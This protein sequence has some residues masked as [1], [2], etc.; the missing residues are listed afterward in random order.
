MDTCSCRNI[1]EVK[2]VTCPLPLMKS[3][4]LSLD[5]FLSS[6]NLTG[7]N[8]WFLPS[9][10]WIYEQYETKIVDFSPSVTAL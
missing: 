7:V 3:I 6:E 8:K 1:D 2:L 4:S 9:M 5:R 10:K